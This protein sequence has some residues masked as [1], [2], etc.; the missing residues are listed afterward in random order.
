M[1]PTWASH[2]FMHKV[3]D[4][5]IAIQVPQSS[6]APR[7]CAIYVQ[8]CLQP[9]IQAIPRPGVASRL[10]STSTNMCCLTPPPSDLHLPD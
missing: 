9:L 8:T 1:L 6:L 4:A 3:L 2:I 5:D 10:G 7:C